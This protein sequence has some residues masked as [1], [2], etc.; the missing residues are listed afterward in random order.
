MIRHLWPLALGFGIWAFAFCTIYALQYLGCYLGWNPALHRAVLVI[1]YVA[2]IGML[3]F[4]LFYQIRLARKPQSTSL[5][6][7]GVSASLAALA[8]TAIT[9]APTLFVSA[10]I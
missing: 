5:D 10:C 9:F 7:I 4:I 6:K 2:T 1:A 3:A 8:A